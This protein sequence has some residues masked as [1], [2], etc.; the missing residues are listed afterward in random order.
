MF[1][2][3]RKIADVLLVAVQNGWRLWWYRTREVSL[4]WR[5]SAELEFVSAPEGFSADG[6]WWKAE[7]GA[8]SALSRPRSEYG[9]KW[10]LP[11]RVKPG[12]VTFAALPAGVTA[13]ENG[14]FARCAGL[15]QVEMP[16]SVTTIGDSAFSYCS[17][18]MRLEIPSS[19]TMIGQLA[20]FC[21]SGLRQLEIPPGVTT[22][23]ECA[24]DGCAGLTRLDIPPS[25]T[26]IGRF[27][28]QG[29]SRMAQLQIPSNFRNLGDGVFIGV[30]RIERLTLVGLV[31]SPRVVAALEGCLLSTA[32]VVG[33]AL[34]GRKFGPFMFGSGRLGRFTPG[35]GKFGRFAIVAS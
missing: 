9:G 6:G 30:M 11:S 13:I 27:A 25:V 7:D 33:P 5:P 15:R 19:V 17:S 18:L 31:L 14:A 16:S 24:C 1:A 26:T 20:F 2:L 21:C 32:R 10:T 29:C 34:A 4:Q 12:D 28:F 22:I 3:E 23:G 35:G 8:E